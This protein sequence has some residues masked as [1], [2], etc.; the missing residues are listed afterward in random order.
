MNKVL[1]T[2]FLPFNKAINNYSLEV[3]KHIKNVDKIILDVLYDEAYY[4]LKEKCDLS[5]YSLIISLGEARSRNELTIE[6]QAL[7]ISKCSIPDNGGIYRNG[8]EIV[9]G[10]GTLKTKV[11]IGKCI[12]I[13]KLSDDAGKFVCN[14]LYYH[15]LN[16][17]PDKS[18]FIHIP[19]CH[20]KEELYI[21]YSSKIEE[22]IKILL[23]K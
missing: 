10:Q 17:Y 3:S 14:N 6:T 1:I 7:N 9:I 11:E 23:D 5:K 19:N 13:G 16:D 8:E 12:G 4:N 20:D 15:L 22:I 21:F 18:V 2:S